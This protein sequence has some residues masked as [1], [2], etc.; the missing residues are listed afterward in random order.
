MLKRSVLV[1]L[2]VSGSIDAYAA[3][4]GI[5]VSVNMDQNAISLPVVFDGFKLEPYLG[6]SKRSSKGDAYGFDTEYVEFGVGL[7]KLNKFSDNY[8]LFYG[9]DLGYFQDETGSGVNKLESTGVGIEPKL[10]LEYFLSEHVTISG[11]VGYLWLDSDSEIGG[12][13]ENEVTTTTT[14]TS[15]GISFYFP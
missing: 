1:G 4:V 8:R 9:V 3:D 5:S 12:G 11:S 6:A 13:D 15:L 7:Y 2:L 14:T 10:G